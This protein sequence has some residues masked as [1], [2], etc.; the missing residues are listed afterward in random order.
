MC[1]SLCELVCVHVCVCVY[2]CMHAC[3]PCW[4]RQQDGEAC[5]R[6]NVTCLCRIGSAA[7]LAVIPTSCAHGGTAERKDI[8]A[9]CKKKA[10]RPKE[11]SV[12]Q[13]QPGPDKDCK[14]DK[15]KAAK[16]N[17]EREEKQPEGCGKDPK[18]MEEREEKPPEGCNKHPKLVTIYPRA[19]E[20]WLSSLKTQE[21]GAKK[22]HKQ[23]TT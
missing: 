20:L 23:V 12:V 13:A 10:S 17:A 22:K 7:L 9:P 18:S 14:S 1:V 3:A 15:A 4:C 19:A 5:F 11:Y 21:E 2:V 8:G 6:V 16:S